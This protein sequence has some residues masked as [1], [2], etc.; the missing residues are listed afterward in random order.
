M[1]FQS[2]LHT[3]LKPARPQEVR[4]LNLVQVFRGLPTQARTALLFETM[5]KLAGSVHHTTSFD[6]QGGINDPNTLKNAVQGLSVLKNLF[7]L[8]PPSPQDSV[9][10]L[11]SSKSTLARVDGKHCKLHILNRIVWYCYSIYSLR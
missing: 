10:S 3:G 11:L 6:L 8:S 2:T 7:L 5:R 1:H 9:T 4:T